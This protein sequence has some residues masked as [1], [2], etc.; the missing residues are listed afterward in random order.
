MRAI[1]VLFFLAWS[2]S[3][4][5]A[6]N[7]A[8]KKSE[9]EVSDLS[10][11]DAHQF[12]YTLDNKK[13]W[14]ESDVCC[15]LGIAA[16]IS[17][18]VGVVGSIIAGLYCQNYG[19]VAECLNNC[20]NKDG[21]ICRNACHDAFGL[22][23]P[24]HPVCITGA[25]FVA[26]CLGAWT[27]FGLYRP[28]TWSYNKYVDWNNDSRQEWLRKNFKKG[29]SDEHV[30]SDND[31]DIDGLGLKLLI[32]SSNLLKQLS[33]AQALN[34]AERHF[35]LVINLGEN[36]FH[37]GG[38]KRIDDVR[39]FLEM[40]A[41]ELSATLLRA[42]KVFTKEPT[43]W[44]TL[45]RLLPAK[46]ILNE[47]VR[48][49]LGSLLK[50]ILKEESDKDWDDVI[51]QVRQGTNLSAFML[52]ELLIN[53]VENDQIEL[54]CGED[55]Y[56][57]SASKLKQTSQYFSRGLSDDWSKKPFEQNEENR[58]RLLILNEV[59]H[60][61]LQIT[62]ENI[63]QVLDAATFF[64]MEKTIQQCDKFIRDSWVSE[65]HN[66]IRAWIKNDP[67]AGGLN[68]KL[69]ST[70]WQ[71][72][73]K[74]SLIRLKRYLA[75]ELILR[76]SEVDDHPKNYEDLLL[77]VQ[78]NLSGVLVDQSINSLAAQ[79]HKP[80]F[81]KWLFEHG[82]SNKDIKNIIIDFVKTKN[83][84]KIIKRAWVVVPQDLLQSCDDDNEQEV[85]VVEYEE[86]E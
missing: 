72:S 57:M 35:Y 73:K 27:L 4:H 85:E 79:L 40:D 3:G 45:V 80:R 44:Q 54:T 52:R 84:K 15:R 13:S 1:F 83:S 7:A 2:L 39:K 38:W 71:F 9:L 31:F 11:G 36:A 42:Q 23:T 82:W 37:K 47:E 25:T 41:Q 8:S 60:G 14:D 28:I 20:P 46:N 77:L 22:Q 17:L 5:A 64:G 86:D 75:L 48:K 51:D 76:L 18:A 78:D 56:L 19:T 16:G 30:L 59:V 69:F 74:F 21:Y 62:V 65:Q 32:M 58:Q 50:A 61:K 24:D 34:L 26:E 53:T 49:S 67:S 33:P 29:R 6:D 55:T 63:W 43:L 12:L 70:H 10:L 68:S 81:L 66:I